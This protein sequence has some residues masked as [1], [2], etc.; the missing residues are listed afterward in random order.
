[1]RPP[2]KTTRT[3]VTI[4][5]TNEVDHGNEIQD[6]LDSIGSLKS[7]GKEIS[8]EQLTKLKETVQDF[9]NLKTVTNVKQTKSNGRVVLC[10]CVLCCSA[11]FKE[12]PR[13]GGGATLDIGRQDKCQ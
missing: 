9:L 11:L 5:T 1:M 6:L 2:A 3:A 12:F 8:D 10:L 4:T 13:G 7:K